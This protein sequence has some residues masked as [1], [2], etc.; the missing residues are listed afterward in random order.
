LPQITRVPNRTQAT[1]YTETKDDA[2]HPWRSL[3]FSGGI[4]EA[5]FVPEMLQR[6][7]Y[8]K[9]NGNFSP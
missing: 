4:P 7:K 6:D 3:R 5:S 9:I 8:R 1:K 2:F